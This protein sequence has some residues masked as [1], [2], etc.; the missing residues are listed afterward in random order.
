MLLHSVGLIASSSGQT[1]GFGF[2]MVSGTAQSLWQPL[3]QHFRLPG[4]SVSFSHISPFL[5]QRGLFWETLGHVP[6]LSSLIG[7]VHERLQPSWQHLLSP[8]HSWSDLH[9]S[10]LRRQSLITL[11]R[12]G[13]WPGFSKID[14]KTTKRLHLKTEIKIHAFMKCCDQST[15][16]IKQV[17]QRVKVTTM[18]IPRIKSIKN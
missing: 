12:H 18:V 8:W 9:V 6:G 10:A 3:W 2:R 7:L 17:Y 11:L 16:A 5:L 14:N 13:Q 1:P 15:N 4:Q